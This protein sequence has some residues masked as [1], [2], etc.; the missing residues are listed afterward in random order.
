ME[1]AEKLRGDRA[2]VTRQAIVAA[3]R[4]LFAE[5][6]YA[7]TPVRLL[8]QEAGVAVRTVYLC[9]GSKQGVLFALVDSLGVDA[10]ELDTRR[11]A[12]EVTDGAELLALAARLYRNLY[13]RGAGVIDMV[14]QGA[15]VDPELTAALR[16]GHDRSRA[17]VE[18]MC[19]RLRELGQ[20]RAGLDVDR[21]AGH[22]LVLLSREGYEELVELRGWSNDAYEAWL[23]SALQAALLE[24][25]R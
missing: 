13:E 8:A 2:D 14:R 4:R 12:A 24:V 3:A 22:G 10:G 23:A 18:A 25:A 9:F 15:A 1:A 21:A 11:A 17:S 20:L 16:H 7:R 5:R 19:D 6:G